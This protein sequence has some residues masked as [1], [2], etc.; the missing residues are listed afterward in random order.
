[1]D[2]QDNLN[3][4]LLPEGSELQGNQENSSQESIAAADVESEQSNEETNETENNTMAENENQPQPEKSEIID[5]ANETQ[6]EPLPEFDADL[7]ENQLDENDSELLKTEPEEIDYSAYS[8]QELLQLLKQLI[9]EKPVNAIK[10]EIDS[11]KKAYYRSRQNEIVLL[12]KQ[13]IDKGGIAETFEIPRDTDEDYFKELLN[14]YKARKSVY[15]EQ[16]EKEKQEN[17]V[18]KKQIIE[19]IGLLANRDE[20]LARTYDEF[21]DLQKQWKEIGLVPQADMQNIL[22][23][24]Q[25]QIEKFYDFIKIDKELRDLDLKKNLDLKI[26]LCNK[27]ESLLIDPDVVEAYKKLQEYHQ[28]WKELGPVPAD[29]REEVWER[30]QVATRQIN[31]NHQDYFLK[32]KEE[33]EN[34][35]KQKE[36]VCEQAEALL[37]EPCDTIAQWEDISKKFTELQSIWKSIGMVPRK[38]NAAVYERFRAACNTFFEN[39]KQFFS[40]IRD[41][42]NNNLQ[43]KIELCIQAESIKESTDW[44]KTTNDFLLLQKQWKEIGPVP[45]KQSQEIWLRFRKA[46]DSFFNTKQNYFANIDNEFAT[47]LNLKQTL[48]NEVTSFSDTGSNSGNL[49]KLREFQNRWIEIG[50]VPHKEKERLQKDFR[51][52]INELYTRLNIQK[53]SLDVEGFKQRIQILVDTGNIDGLR[54]ERANIIQKQKTLD[55]EITQ[56]ENNMSF[57]SSKAESLLIDVKRKIE[58]AK[59][60]MEQLAEQKKTVD[61]AERELRSKIEKKA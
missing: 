8:K 34:N 42:Q 15:N 61:L 27:A 1:M 19:K 16:I 45:R 12:K 56:L 40:Q 39:K 55:I 49:E 20:S 24:Y 11:I 2:N 26:E 48:I 53:Q 52:A 58:K 47:N 37:L 25:M 21:R 60:E 6:F 17:L 59:A 36:I 35:L 57:F 32:I 9:Y 14:D 23:S 50:Q 5:S 4:D 43:R 54:R 51:N 33:L 28:Q 38:N 46:C 22:N 10:L 41:E 7:S 44:K 13:F 30:F 29:K 3:H 31:K 18:L